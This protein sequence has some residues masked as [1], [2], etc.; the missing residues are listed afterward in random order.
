MPLTIICPNLRCR[1]VLQVPASVRGQK[2]RCGKCGKDL[3]VP[4][5]P[6][7][8]KPLKEV[9]PSAEPPAEQP[10]T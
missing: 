7:P 6:P 9:K 1:S 10:A 8:P 4:T 5:T 2:V 3:L